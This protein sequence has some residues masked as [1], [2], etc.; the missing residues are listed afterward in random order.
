MPRRTMSAPSP[1]RAV[2]WPIVAPHAEPVEIGE[3]GDPAASS[4]IPASL[5]MTARSPARAARQAA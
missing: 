3:P 5:R 2:S 4:P 1:M